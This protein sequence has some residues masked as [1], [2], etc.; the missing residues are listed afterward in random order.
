MAELASSIAGLLGVTAKCSIA[1]TEFLIAVREAPRDILAL[2]VELKAIES[3]L[4]ELQSAFASRNWTRPPSPKWTTDLGSILDWCMDIIIE[5]SVL[6]KKL[7]TDASS[8]WGGRTWKS[9]RWTFIEG[10]VKKLRDRL[11][12]AKNTLGLK[13]QSLST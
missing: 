13:L 6:V 10:D 8:S 1:L 11:E 4:G 12:S 3:V 7:K 2:Q 9:I 5:L